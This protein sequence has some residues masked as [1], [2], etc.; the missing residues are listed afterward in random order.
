MLLI[1]RIS[2]L[3]LFDIQVIVTMEDIPKELI[4][5]WDHNGLHYIPVSSWIMAQEGSQRVKICGVQDKRQLTAVLA[6]TMSGNF[7]PLQ[8]VKPQCIIYR[9]RR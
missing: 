8:I 3:N 9:Q 7:L 2:M 6:G 5:N 4:I 1:L